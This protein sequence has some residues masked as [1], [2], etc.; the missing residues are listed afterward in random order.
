MDELIIRGGRL[1]DGTGA[2]AREADVSVSDGRVVAIEARSARPARREIDARGQ[3]IA[4]GFIDIHTHSDFTL[5]LNPR[6]ES[7]VRQG[8]TTEIVGNCGFSAAPALPGRA[9]VLREFLASS[10]P[11][12]PFHETTFA[13][14][15][16]AFPPTSVN[17]ILQVGHHTLR[18]MT[19]GMENRPLTS[20]E[21][22]AM[23]QLLEE[24]LRAGA[25]GLSSGLFT[26][27]GGFADADEI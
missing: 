14:Y 6:A 16:A 8:V 7:K 2:P 17:V 22:A 20:A 3:V 26:A 13:E 21:G 27:P 5:P 12:L 4:P 23:E 19:A 11:W 9:D 10:A 25:W 24:A 1:S 18:L 15:V